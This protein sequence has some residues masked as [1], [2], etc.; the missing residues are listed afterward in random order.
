MA[1]IPSNYDSAK[2]SVDPR[3]ID[4][5]AQ[6]VREL[7]GDIATS[8]NTI[9]TSMNSLLL[10]WAGN[11]ATEAEALNK[12][13]NAISTKLYGTQADQ[14]KGLF[15]RL[16]MGLETAAENY[17]SNENSVTKMFEKFSSAMSGGSNHGKSDGSATVVDHTSPGNM[18][19]TA[20]D[21]RAS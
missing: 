14:G 9:Q 7:V 12:R 11:A 3:E 18:H 1:T 10:S 19:T 17:S 15:S 6:S 16:I 5:T 13:W 2:I 21:E 4:V 8:L 20:V